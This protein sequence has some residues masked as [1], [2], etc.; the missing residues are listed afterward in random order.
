MGFDPRWAAHIEGNVYMAG[1]F[2]LFDYTKPGKGI[3]KDAPQK[4][5]FFLFFELVWRK[6]GRLMLLNLM[7]FVAVL[8]IVCV[9]YYVWYNF[10]YGL[11]TPEQL[12]AASELP[13][14]PL[15][16]I[17][18]AAVDSIPAVLRY[19]LL[20]ASVVIYGPVN[21]GLTYMLRNFARQQHAWN[22][23]FFER[24][25]SNF[26]QGLVIGLLD[27]FFA[28]VL[29]FNLTMRVDPGAQIATLLNLVRYV[30]YGLLL[31]YLFARNYVFIMVVTF[32]NTIR[33]IIK[34][35][36]IFSVIGLWRN[37]IVL[38]VNLVLILTMLL[39]PIV[40]LVFVP[41]LLFSFMGFVAVYACY[42]L[43]KKHMIDPLEKKEEIIA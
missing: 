36:W 7:Y 34:N 17:L 8:P 41:L 16:G 6:L 29:A 18:L 12:G 21:C 25:K 37:L 11:M 4:H 38:A 43:I 5:P 19:V 10:I 30:S 13:F 1:I 26:K 15:A 23:D 28:C 9:F 22:T 2:G 35:A 3:D 31:I 32:D 40:E 39:I 24:I 27:L 33:Q 42:P 20:A 14:S